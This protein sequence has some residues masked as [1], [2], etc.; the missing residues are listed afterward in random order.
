MKLKALIGAVILT[1]AAGASAGG[2]VVSNNGSYQD[3]PIQIASINND[4]FR[5]T[6][7]NSFLDAELIS[8]LINE[9]KQSSTANRGLQPIELNN[10]P[11]KMEIRDEPRFDSDLH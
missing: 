7:I 8:K 4:Y 1:Y 5:F 10:K 6:V 11:P 2:S 3:N 9:E